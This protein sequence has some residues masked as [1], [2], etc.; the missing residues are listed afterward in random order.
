MNNKI[1]LDLKNNYKS[2][3]SQKYPG[4][5]INAKVITITKDELIKID[6][7]KYDEED[8]ML[9]VCCKI[10]EYLKFI[11]SY[12]QFLTNFELTS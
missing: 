9:V 3:I 1:E 5:E 12:E 11:C 2:K 7:I 10:H 6:S 8:H 4:Y